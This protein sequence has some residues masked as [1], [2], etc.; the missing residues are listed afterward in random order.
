MLSNLQEGL[1]KYYKSVWD[2]NINANNYSLIVIIYK[3][4]ILLSEKECQTENK[5]QKISEKLDYFRIENYIMIVKNDHKLIKIQLWKNSKN[6]ARV[7]VC[8]WKWIR[9]R[10]A[11]TPTDQKMLNIAVIAFNQGHSKTVLP[12]QLKW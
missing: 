2:A 8:L 5:S 3:I 12:H 10:E 4:K 1:K 6:S 7:V 11:L 9:K